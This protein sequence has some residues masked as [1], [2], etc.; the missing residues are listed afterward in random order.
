LPT[1]RSLTALP[2][3]TA[4]LLAFL[5]PAALVAQVYTCANPDGSVAYRQTPC[6]AV[7]K[8][9]AAPP[10]EAVRV[11]PAADCSTARQLAFST[12][13][14]MQGGLSEREVIRELGGDSALT[15]AARGIVDH[16]LTFA[17]DADASAERIASLSETLCRGGSFGELSCADLPAG[18]ARIAA[19]CVADEHRSAPARRA[20]AADLPPQPATEAERLEVRA[21]REPIERRIEA[22]DIELRRGTT[23][24]RAERYLAE[25]L[26][27]TDQLRSC[28]TQIA[29]SGD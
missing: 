27:L 7:S 5:M 14:W 10:A 21:C 9:A 6:P 24:E 22:I 16:V 29:A 25:L 12:A 19:G 18:N 17:G 20:T 15:D 1:L 28:A 8:P 26:G 13:R 4:G 23:G 3:A 11:N 2:V